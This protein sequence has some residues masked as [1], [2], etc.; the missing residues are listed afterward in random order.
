MHINLTHL[1]R[2]GFEVYMTPDDEELHVDPIHS[3]DA[4]GLHKALLNQIVL[5][6]PD[7]Y[8]DGDLID[9]KTRQFIEE[10]YNL[11]ATNAVL[12]CFEVD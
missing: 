9:K 2:K 12:D 8:F 1:K 11:F 3:I 4:A 5:F 10:L 6:I 7:D